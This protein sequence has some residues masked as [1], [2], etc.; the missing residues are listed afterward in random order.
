MRSHRED[1]DAELPVS[2]PI[3]NCL[4][5]AQTLTTEL[6]GLTEIKQ[7]LELKKRVPALSFTS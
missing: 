6:T 7:K 5:N 2:A 1:A 4:S 3:L